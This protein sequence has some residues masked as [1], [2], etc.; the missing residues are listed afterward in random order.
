MVRSH[1]A[2]RKDLRRLSKNVHFFILNKVLPNIAENPY[3]GT[4]LHGPLKG[5]W[6]LQTG[7]YRISYLIDNKLRE[8]VIIEIGPRGG[9]YNRLR[10]RLGK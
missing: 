4:P 3:R 5:Y 8:V 1:P 9:F 2:V 6:K 10:D 7:E